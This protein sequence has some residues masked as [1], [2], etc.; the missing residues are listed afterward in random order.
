MADIYGK[1]TLKTLDL[2]VGGTAYQL[3]QPSGLDEVKKPEKIAVVAPAA[4]TTN[5]FVGAS[6]VQP[7]GTAFLAEVAP[8]ATVELLTNDVAALYAVSATAGDDL[9][10]AYFSHKVD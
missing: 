9:S 6:S 4:N 10:V 5:V 2:T 1:F 8:G 3:P 7:T